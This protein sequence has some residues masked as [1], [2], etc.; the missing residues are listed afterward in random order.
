MKHLDFM[1]YKVG[2]KVDVIRDS[3]GGYYPD[4][5]LKILKKHDF[6]MTIVEVR[7]DLEEFW[8]HMKEDEGWSAWYESSIKN[9]AKKY[10]PINDRFEIMDL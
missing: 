8:Y 9:L 7:Y 6:V 4:K 2:D 5:L 1:K 10:E 3:E